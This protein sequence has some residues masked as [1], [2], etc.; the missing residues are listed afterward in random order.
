ML[1]SSA[2]PT[3]QITT[4]KTSPTNTQMVVPNTLAVTL[5]R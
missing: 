5:P 3:F 4:I 1:R 2:M